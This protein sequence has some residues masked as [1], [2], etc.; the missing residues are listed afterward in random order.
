VAIH[1]LT[2]EAVLSGSKKAVMQ[3]LLADLNVDK[4]SAAEAMLE[5]ILQRQSQYLGY[6]Q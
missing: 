6:I 3:A 5:T 4:V 1:E 2:A